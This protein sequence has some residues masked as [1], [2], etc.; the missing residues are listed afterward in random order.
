MHQVS[1]FNFYCTWTIEICM[2]TTLKRLPQ[3]HRYGLHHYNLITILNLLNSTRLPPIKYSSD[4]FVMYKFNLCFSI[5]L[6]VIICLL[7]VSSSYK[8]NKK[9]TNNNFCVL[10]SL[11]FIFLSLK[12]Y[13][14]NGI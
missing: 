11:C 3:N 9:D 10:F 7:Y 8:N 14:H 13:N 4:A 5:S 1:Q 12:T 6:S 2:Q